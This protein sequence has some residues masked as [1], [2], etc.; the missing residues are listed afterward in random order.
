MF[1]FYFIQI[2]KDRYLAIYL[3]IAK[4]GSLI[5]VVLAAPYWCR[6][7]LNGL[8]VLCTKSPF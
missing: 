2:I 5:R 3:Q 7:L 6:K 8:R 1:Y 4:R